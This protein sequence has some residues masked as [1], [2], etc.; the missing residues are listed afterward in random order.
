VIGNLPLKDSP[1]A[2]TLNLFRYACH[3]VVGKIRICSLVAE[4]YG[5]A[6]YLFSN[7]SSIYAAP[8]PLTAD[9]SAAVAQLHSAAARIEIVAA[10]RKLNSDHFPAG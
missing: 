8:R 7:P 2:D 3:T 5:H 4:Y 9:V 10:L 6:R 1:T